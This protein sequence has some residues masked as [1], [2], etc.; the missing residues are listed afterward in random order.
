M[1]SIVLKGG[2]VLD[3]TGERVADVVVEDG[4]IA[5]IGSDLH[6]DEILDV[7]QSGIV[8]PGLVAFG[9]VLRGRPDHV[10]EE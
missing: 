4:L 3:A 6:A 9:L 8:A 1:K 5:A 2:R 7:G 10:G